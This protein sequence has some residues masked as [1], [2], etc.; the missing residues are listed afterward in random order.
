MRNDTKVL[1]LEKLRVRLNW[2]KLRVSIVTCTPR[3]RDFTH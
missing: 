3:K 1:K 2:K